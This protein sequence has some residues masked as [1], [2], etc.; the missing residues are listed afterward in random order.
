MKCFQPVIFLFPFYALAQ[1][2]SIKKTTDPYT[3]E[4]RISTGFI[5]LQGASL[6]I[7]ADSREIDFFFSMTGVEKCFSDASTAVVVYEGIKMKGNYKNGGPV[8]C[9]GFFHII[10]KNGP[11]TPALLQ[12]LIS[13]KISSIQF[14]GNNKTQTTITFSPEDQQILIAK[15]DCLIKEARTLLK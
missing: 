2:C 3:K 14:T 1:D 4:V 8:N 6:A 13:Q 15:A 5:E 11:A 10:F 12:R 9:D 7:E